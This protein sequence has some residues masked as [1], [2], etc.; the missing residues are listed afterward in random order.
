MAQNPNKLILE[1]KNQK[2]KNKVK[3]KVLKAK[4]MPVVRDTAGILHKGAGTTAGLEANILDLFLNG[5]T[6]IQVKRYLTEELGMGSSP[7]MTRMKKVRD[8]LKEHVLKQRE[9]FVNENVLVLRKIITDTLDTS[10]YSIAIDAIR[11][12]NRMFQVYDEK[13]N[14]NINANN[15]GFDFGIA[16][17][18]PVEI[19]DAEEVVDEN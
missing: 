1:T 6:S 5:Y 2:K 15:Y 9:Q 4:Q 12:L 13:V 3:N 10:R 14:I 11:E 16:D 19:K 18:Q 7:A 8:N 17:E